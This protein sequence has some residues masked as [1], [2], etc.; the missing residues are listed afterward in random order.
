MSAIFSTRFQMD[1]SH[2][3]PQQTHKRLLRVIAAARL[4]VFDLAYAFD[5]FPLAEF[6]Q[7]IS[8]EAIAIVRDSQ[9]WSQLIPATHSTQEQFAIFCFHFQS[10]LDNSG[11]VGWLASH[12]KQKLGTGV[13]VICGQNSQDGGIFDYWGC[14]L[15][16]KAQ[17]IREIELLIHQGDRSS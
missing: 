9:L 14:P 10:G 5:E 17:A 15:S 7:K 3:T 8:S 16:I 13:F 2:E 11:F 4:E 1:I 6:P 12:L